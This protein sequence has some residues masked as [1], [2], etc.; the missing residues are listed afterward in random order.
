[1][2]DFVTLPRSDFEWLLACYWS[3]LSGMHDVAENLL[4]EWGHDP[5]GHPE[6]VDA[7]ELELSGALIETAADVMRE[8]GLADLRVESEAHDHHAPAPT[9]EGAPA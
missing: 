5:A 8:H 6:L 1:M 2:T 3:P 9:G 7:M 4:I